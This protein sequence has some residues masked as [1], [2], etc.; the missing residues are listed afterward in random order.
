MKRLAVLLT[1]CVL[2]AGTR[3]SAQPPLLA[4][5]DIS[6][7]DVGG[8]SGQVLLADVDNDGHLDLLTR[9]QQARRI[10]TH[11]GDGSAHFRTT[12]AP[13]A[14]DFPP[15][16]MSLGDLNGDRILDL[17]VTA[18]GRDV[19]DALLGNGQGGFTRAQGA[20][21]AASKRRYRYTKRSLHLVDVDGDG[22]LDIIT[23]NR[24]GQYTFRVLRG[25]GSGR[26]GDGPVLT[27][28]PAQE[29]YTL[30]FGDVDGDGDVD[31]VTAVSSP[32]TGRVDVHLNNGR[33]VFGRI[34]GS[35][36][37]S[38]PYQIEALAEV[39]SDRRPDLVV[40]HRSGLLTVLLNRGRGRFARAPGSPFALAARPFSVATADLNRDDQTDLVAATEG[41]VTVLLGRGR[42]FP[43]DLQSTF[44]AGPGAF[45]VTVGDLNEDRRPDV[46][47]SSFESNGVTVLLGR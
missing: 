10:R 47:A 12:G 36:V 16:D 7:F 35:V 42:A 8:P 17:V 15:A 22:N 9:H 41:S 39:N 21:F 27:V 44:R 32:R 38:A 6:P 5:A 20:P 34:R 2:G 33:E 31:A 19:V 4:P 18:G 1:L 11:L 37:L 25:D 26:F 45:N 28:E 14:L 3:G 43:R 40:S 13:I 23:G 30:V 24:R 29:G 46:V